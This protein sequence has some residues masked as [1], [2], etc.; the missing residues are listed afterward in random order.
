[1]DDAELARKLKRAPSIKLIHVRGV[2]GFFEVARENPRMAVADELAALD[3]VA[4]RAAEAE[5]AIMALGWYGAEALEDAMPVRQTLSDAS[6]QLAAIAS[7]ASAARQSLGEACRSGRPVSNLTHVVQMLADLIE[8]GGGTVDA[9]Q[10]GELC[11]AF[12][13]VVEALGLSVENQRETV[14]AALKRRA[15]RQ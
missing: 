12:G 4:R 8:D 10:G 5:A 9:T 6:R 1:M 13:V 3:L 15:A 11:Q 14:R 2:I 7:A